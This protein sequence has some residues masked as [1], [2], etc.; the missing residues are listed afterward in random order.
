MSLAAVG[1]YR[2]NR[3]RQRLAP[4]VTMAPVSMAKV[5]PASGTELVPSGVATD[6]V[7]VSL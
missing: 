2:A 3:R 5:E 6:Q 7:I 4:N 1:S